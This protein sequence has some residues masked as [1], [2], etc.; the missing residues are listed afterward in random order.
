MRHTP[1]PQDRPLNLPAK[2]TPQPVQKPAESWKKTDREGVEIDQ[3]G[4]RRTK[5]PFSDMQCDAPAGSIVGDSEFGVLF[6]AVA[7]ADL[8]GFR[9]DWGMAEE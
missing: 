6:S 1:E 3:D 2:A 8:I 9:A 5:L 7:G 4:N